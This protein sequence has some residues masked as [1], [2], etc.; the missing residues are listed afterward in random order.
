VSNIAR[1]SPTTNQ[2]SA[3]GPGRP[4]TIYSLDALP[5]GDLLAGGSSGGLARYHP[6]T[7]SWTTFGSGIIGT[8]INLPGGDVI[9]GGSGASQLFRFSPADNTSTPIAGLGSNDGVG[10]LAYLGP[11]Q[12]L[13]GGSIT[14]A[15][16]TPTTNL[17]RLNLDTGVWSGFGTDTAGT[18]IDGEVTS[19]TALPHNDFLMGGDFTRAGTVTTA[20]AARW[21]ATSAD[22]N[23]DGDPGT[24]QDIGSFFQCLAGNCCPL[25]STDFNGDGDLGTDQDIEAFFRVLGGGSC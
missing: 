12:L 10:A 2:W 14:S 23:H 1:F 8:M 25:C 17:A 18:G 13:V 22:Y 7:L 5:D 20:F 19:L 6:E 15:G 21:I 11:N 24:D 4:N 9:V 3:L 16:G